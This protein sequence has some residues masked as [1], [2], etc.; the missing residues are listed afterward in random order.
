[1]R[2]RVTPPVIKN[3]RIELLCED[4]SSQGAGIGHFKG[5]ALFVPGLLP[6]ER[7]L[8]Q[9]VKVGKQYGY[10]KLIELLAAS[11]ERRTPFCA[12][13]PQCGGCLLQHMAYEAQLRW[14]QQHVY[15]LLRRV[16]GVPLIE[17][18]SIRGME[19]GERLHY[20]NKAQF[21]VR[22][23]D[24]HLRAGFFAPRSHRLIPLTQ[25]LIQSEASNLL[26]TPLLAFL[27]QLGV[28]A[29]NEATGEGLLR[30]ILIRDGRRSGEV[31][32]CLVIN[33]RELPEEPRIASFLMER[34]VTSVSVNVN[35]SRTNVILGEKTRVIGGKNAI[36][37][38]IGPLT[39]TISPTSFFQVNPV[40]TER[41][42]QTALEMVELIG[43]EV[44]W[45]A[46]CGAGTISLFLAQK[47]KQV[48]GV[49]IVEAAVRNAW[50]N[51][52]KN[53]MDNVK[54][55]VGKAEQVIP[56]HF[57]RTGI[58]P[59]VIVVDPP[60]AG[61]DEALLHTILEMKPDRMVY[62]SCD[63]GT[64]ARDLRFLGKGGMEV[65]EVRCI[66][67]FP[68]TG[69]VETVV[70]LSKGK[71]DSK[72]IRV[73]FSLEDMDLSD[74]LDGSNYTQIKEY[75]LEHS[76]LKVSNLY[77]SQIKRKCGIEVGQNY[78]LPKSEDSR[79]PLCPPEKEK[80]IREAFKYFG[81]I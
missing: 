54:F 53:G 50:E 76:G 24:G 48:Y 15:E 26:L 73:E 8:V 44:V 63:P 10:G 57:R 45:D 51:A 67:M 33:G 68:E 9:V 41:L 55:Y 74:F 19:E 58:R 42:Y 64:L 77:I 20:R 16:G 80:A 3:Q 62:V 61:C 21:P 34:G 72:K 11:S 47:A 75:V 38:Q 22:M 70:L 29:Y 46:Y 17:W 7:G 56:E 25:C 43:N 13:F 78:N 6:S 4:L 37:E 35:V 31:L 81:M 65:R 32:V 5:Y 79:Q 2:E 30:H 59:D 40:Q 23:I 1:M 69:H 52:A 18:P 27:E 60:R 14:K 36:E 66:D 49:E 39:F 71:V 28:T 12:A